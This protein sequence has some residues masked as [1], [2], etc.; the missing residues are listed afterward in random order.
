MLCGCQVFSYMISFQIIS[1]FFFFFD[2]VLYLFSSFFLR[3]SSYQTSIWF[4]SPIF[5]SQRTRRRSNTSYAYILYRCMYSVVCTRRLFFGIL[6]FHCWQT[7][8]VY[9]I[10]L[11]RFLLVMPGH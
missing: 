9:N 5:L 7:R 10:E 6:L 8:L 1:L 2:K 11:G 4:M 3:N